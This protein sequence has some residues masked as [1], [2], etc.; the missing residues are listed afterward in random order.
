MVAEDVADS[1]IDDLPKSCLMFSIS[2]Q[3]PIVVWYVYGKVCT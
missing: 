1:P 2:T 3:T